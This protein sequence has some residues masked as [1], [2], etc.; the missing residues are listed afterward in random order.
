M[1]LYFFKHVLQLAD[2]RI[3]DLLWD[4]RW[5]FDALRCFF[6][7]E[8]LF[9]LQF[10]S[11][12]KVRFGE[13]RRALMS[14]VMYGTAYSTQGVRWGAEGEWVTYHEITSFQRG[15]WTSLLQK[16]LVVT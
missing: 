14:S 6:F 11:T 10:A 2:T 13:F 1:K 4:N 5:R 9:L 3:N 16:E 12:I 8:N 15:E 7:R